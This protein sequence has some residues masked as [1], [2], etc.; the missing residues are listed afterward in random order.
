MRE[1]KFRGKRVDNGEW[2]QG[3]FVQTYTKTKDKLLVATSIF[4]WDGKELIRVLPETVGQYTGLKDK[5]NTEIYEGDIVVCNYK[6]RRYEVR[7]K[8]N[9]FEAITKPD[10]DKFQYVF[11]RDWDDL[12]VIGIIHDNPDR[13]CK[14][15]DSTCLV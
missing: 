13:I 7:Y 9:M 5:N 10:K 12:E 3:N 8:D 11:G 6:K 4:A 2:V 15:T 1:I 14:A